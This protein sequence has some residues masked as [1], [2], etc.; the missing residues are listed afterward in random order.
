[1]IS[2]MG[3]YR[4][5]TGWGANLIVGGEGAPGVVI[6]ARTRK[7]ISTKL[8]GKPKPPITDEH[9]LHMREAKLGKN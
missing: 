5:V 1:M 2:Q 9:R 6:S 4:P 3:T 8:K 7:L